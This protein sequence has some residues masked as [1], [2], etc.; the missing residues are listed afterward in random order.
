MAPGLQER[1]MEKSVT[2]RRD[3]AGLLTAKEGMV[4]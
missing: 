4:A 1:I 3:Q 2:T